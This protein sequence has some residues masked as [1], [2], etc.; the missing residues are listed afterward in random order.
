MLTYLPKIT[1]NQSLS[2]LL[3]K[4]SKKILK[5]QVLTNKDVNIPKKNH[6]KILSKKIPNISTKKD[7]VLTNNKDVGITGG[8]ISISKIKC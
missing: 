7:V 5:D 2:M 4:T 6:L 3:K 8:K 1:I